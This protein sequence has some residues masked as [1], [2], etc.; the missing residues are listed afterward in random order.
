MF[1]IRYR[2]IAYFFSNRSVL[3]ICRL[4]FRAEM[5]SYRVQYEQQRNETGTSRSHTW[6]GHRTGAVGREGFEPGGY[7]TKSYT[8]R[9]R[10]KDQPLTLFR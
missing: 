3:T 8:V 10:P 2:V 7:S 1:L 5:K 6:M 9:L 4:A